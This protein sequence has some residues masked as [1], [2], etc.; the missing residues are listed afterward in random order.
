MV[1]LSGNPDYADY[2][3]LQTDADV[4]PFDVADLVEEVMW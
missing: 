2:I 3:N 1:K 4:A